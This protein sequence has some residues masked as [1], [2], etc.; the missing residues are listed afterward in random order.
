MCYL[1]AKYHGHP[2]KGIPPNT[3][4]PTTGPQ[5][6]SLPL[7]GFSTTTYKVGYPK[8]GAQISPLFFHSFK[9]TVVIGRG[10]GVHPK[11]L[12]I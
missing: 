3:T 11:T 5:S 10:F 12:L 2:S 7:V 1:V 9:K 8:V 6:T 4:P